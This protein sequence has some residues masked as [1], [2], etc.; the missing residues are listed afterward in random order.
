LRAGL[1]GFFP[2]CADR[3]LHRRGELVDALLGQL[4]QFL[5]GGGFLV[6]RLL[7]QLGGVLAAEA[8]REGAGRAVAGDFVMLDALG[9]GDQGGV[10]NGRVARS[11]DRFLSFGEQALHGL[12]RLGLGAAAHALED[13]LQFEKIVPGSAGHALRNSLRRATPSHRSMR[14][15]LAISQTL[16]RRR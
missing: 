14:V 13:T 7:Q 9:G 1:L 16:Y 11:L 6:E 10:L 8:K 2:M 4:R 5:V 3:L 15:N 12:A